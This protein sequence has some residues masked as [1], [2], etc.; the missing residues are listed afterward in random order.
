MDIPE[1]LI[2]LYDLLPNSPIL[3]MFLTRSRFPYLA[4]LHFY[5]LGNLCH[6]TTT[7]QARRNNLYVKWMLLLAVGSRATPSKS[8][9]ATTSN[10]LVVSGPGEDEIDTSTPMIFTDTPSPE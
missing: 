5:F 9:V 3:G 8:T 2:A 10:H 6:P 4:C 7:Y 1:Y